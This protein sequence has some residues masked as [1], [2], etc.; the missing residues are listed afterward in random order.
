MDMKK[1]IH[2]CSIFYYIFEGTFL[3][4]KVG[5]LKKKYFEK[6]QFLEKVS[7]RIK[8]LNKI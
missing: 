7:G 6:T 4:S 1:K 3:H 5:I 8:Y 2:C